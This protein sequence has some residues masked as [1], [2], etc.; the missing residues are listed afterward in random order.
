MKGILAV[1]STPTRVVIQ[2][3]RDSFV[4]TD[5][6]PWESESER[7]SHIV[8]IGKDVKRDAIEKLLSRHL[9]G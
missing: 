9:I 7:I 6:P 2:S 1:N 8:F 3:V 5:G 4:L